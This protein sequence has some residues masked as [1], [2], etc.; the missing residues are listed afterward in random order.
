MLTRLTVKT[1]TGSM[2]DGQKEKTRTKQKGDSGND[3][4]EKAG[5]RELRRFWIQSGSLA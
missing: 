2:R 4:E 1:G 3:N 5:G